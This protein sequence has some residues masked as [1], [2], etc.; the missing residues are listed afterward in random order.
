MGTNCTRSGKKEEGSRN[1]KNFQ[2][3]L[4]TV[5]PPENHLASKE[6]ATI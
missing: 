3:S 5:F 2:S 6:L 4:K 1:D